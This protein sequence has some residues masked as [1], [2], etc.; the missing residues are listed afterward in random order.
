M[1]VLVFAKFD[2]TPEQWADFTKEASIPP[3]THYSGG[4]TSPTVPYVL[5]HSKSQEDYARSEELSTTL[6]TEFSNADYFEMNEF[7][8]SKVVSLPYE[9]ARTLY[10]DFFMVLDEQS[11]KDRTVIVVDRTWER[12]DPEGNIVED[13]TLSEREDVTRGTVWRVHRVPY[14][15]A[16]NFY[17][18]LSMNPGMEGEEFLEEVIRPDA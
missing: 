2:I 17:L 16:L 4:P 13:D 12:L 10:K 8:D 7:I 18:D 15:K 9:Q 6:R 3:P 1:N 5:L 11:V 14:D